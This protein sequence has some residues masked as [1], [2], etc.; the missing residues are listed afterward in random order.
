MLSGWPTTCL[1]SA[2]INDLAGYFVLDGQSVNALKD[3]CVVELYFLF[4]RFT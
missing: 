3:I 4:D 1:S 2:G